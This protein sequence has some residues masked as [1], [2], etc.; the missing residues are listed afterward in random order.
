M[1]LEIIEHFYSDIAVNHVPLRC[2]GEPDF[3]N[4]SLIGREYY[5]HYESAQSYVNREHMQRRPH[6]MVKNQ[7]LS[8]DTFLTA[9]T[10]VHF[11]S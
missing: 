1:Y 9:V 5:E 3:I 8:L 6:E 2:I 4:S 11:Y 7:G 10:T